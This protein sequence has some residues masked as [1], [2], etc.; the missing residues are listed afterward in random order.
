MMAEAN[1]IS[2]QYAFMVSNIGVWEGYLSAFTREGQQTS[3]VPT[4]LYVYVDTEDDATKIRTGQLPYKVVFTLRRC[5]IQRDGTQVFYSGVDMLSAGRAFDSLGSM[6]S[7]AKYLTRG[8]SP[9]YFELNLNYHKES[10][11]ASPILARVRVVVLYDAEGALLSVSLFRERERKSESAAFKCGDARV[12]PQHSSY[13][14]DG[15]GE[16]VGVDSKCQEATPTSFAGSWAGSAERIGPAVP[17]WTEPVIES[18]RNISCEGDR[19]VFVEDGFGLP[20]SR[21]L[22]GIASD[23]AL[24][25]LSAV[26]GLEH[27]MFLGGGVTLKAPLSLDFAGVATVELAWL[28]Q[29]GRMISI[30]RVMDEGAWRF[31]LFADHRKQVM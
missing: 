14:P 7:G 26:N 10:G 28:V 18:K 6:C 23:G 19:V 24:V 15:K 31:S 4:I 17:G 29:P 27:W 30:T 16:F 3:C 1:L 20:G 9:I 8:G 12:L 11:S 13:V 21:K 2:Q 22:E 5:L 25:V